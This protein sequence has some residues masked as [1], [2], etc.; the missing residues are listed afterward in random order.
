MRK[1]SDENTLESIESG[2]SMIDITTITS[3]LTTASYIPKESVIFETD[4]LT[5]QS[6]K[7]SS[8]IEYNKYCGTIGNANIVRLSDEY[9]E[10]KSQNN[11]EHMDCT[12]MV[13][14]DNLYSLS[15]ISVEND[16]LTFN[17]NFV[18]LDIVSQ[19]ESAANSLNTSKDTNQGKDIVLSQSDPIVISFNVTN[20]SY[21]TSLSD[22]SKFPLCSF[23]NETEKVFDDNNCYLLSHNSAICQC[24]CLHAT[25]WGVSSEDFEPQ[26]NML[27]SEEWRSIT[28]NSIFSHPLGMIVALTWM[29]MCVLFIVLAQWHHKKHQILIP[30]CT[31][32]FNKLESINDKPLIAESEAN[33]KQILSDNETKMKYRSIQEIRVIK[34]DMFK[35]RSFCVKFYH[36]FKVCDRM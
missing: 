13:T 28:L 23:Y 26:V 36:L 3:Q 27:N 9:I 12:V 10:F 29:L 33:I 2:Q 11:S 34:D 18:L 16:S 7:I 24:V 35:N 19:K 21:F 4:S 5:V 20:D 1:W 6:S 22:Y 14:K 15:T 8:D 17:S 25:Y 32:L 31:R 30:F